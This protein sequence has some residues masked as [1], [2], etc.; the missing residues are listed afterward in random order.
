MN[1]E[2]ALPSLPPF[3]IFA[4]R[5]SIFSLVAPWLSLR[6]LLPSCP[7]ALLPRCLSFQAPLFSLQ[8][9][10][11]V[12]HA[13]PNARKTTLP[14]RPRAARRAAVALQNKPFP[15]P[16]DAKQMAQTPQNRAKTKNAGAKQSH[17]KVRIIKHNPNIVEPIAASSQ[18]HQLEGPAIR[19]KSRPVAPP[20]CVC[21]TNVATQGHQGWISQAGVITLARQPKQN[22]HPFPKTTDK[23]APF[24]PI[25]N[26]ANLRAYGM[27]HKGSA[28]EF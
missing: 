19:R 15:S 20:P 28:P 17:L 25:D 8:S 6:A 14:V 16:N 24:I 11:L 12:P 9:S 27:P 5:S 21:L 1:F 4:I 10:A 18:L 7:I 23:T 3:S 13:V 2:L 26:M 22:W